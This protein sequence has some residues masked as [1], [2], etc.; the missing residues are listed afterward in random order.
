MSWNLS[1]HLILFF[2]LLISF[3]HIDTQI[4]HF[5]C[6]RNERIYLMRSVVP[7]LFRYFHFFCVYIEMLAWNLQYARTHQP[8]Y[9]NRPARVFFFN[10]FIFFCLIVSLSF[11]QPLRARTFYLHHGPNIKFQNL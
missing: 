2:F 1:I 6:A 8:L 9:T 7:M 5:P 4:E 11:A 3:T 10:I